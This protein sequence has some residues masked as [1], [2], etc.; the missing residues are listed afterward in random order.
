M[1]M[2]I[3]LQKTESNFFIPEYYYHLLFNIKTPLYN[4]IKSKFNLLF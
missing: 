4:K 3:H 2:F 1:K